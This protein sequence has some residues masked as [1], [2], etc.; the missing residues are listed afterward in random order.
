MS[1]PFCEPHEELFGN[2]LAYVKVDEFPVSPGH[3]LI[4]PRR[5]VSSW[6][7]LTGEEHAA[8]A[9]LLVLTKTY[10]DSHYSP[11]GYNI[12][13]NCGEAAGQTIPHAHLHVI[14]R[15]KGDVPN[16][17]GGIRAVIRAKQDYPTHTNSF[18]IG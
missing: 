7:S 12:G 8:A 13:V 18:Y 4:I 1:C 3:V 15:Y 2:E 6:F 17:R 11:D 14:P 10:L 16:P 5:H 9:T